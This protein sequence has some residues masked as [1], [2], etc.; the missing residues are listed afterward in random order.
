MKP[1]DVGGRIPRLRQAFADAGCGALLVTRLVNIRYLT[2]FTGSAA[3]LLVRPDDLVFVTDGRYRDQ[4]ALE[5]G[6]AG[7][8]ARIRIG[9]TAGSQKEYLQE[10]VA[11][12]ARLGLEASSVSWAAQR[13]YDDDW[14]PDAELVATE[15][16]VEELRKVKDAGEVER[17][18]AAARIADEALARVRHR[19]AEGPTEEEFALE[20]D[21]EMRRGGA[22]GPSF[23]TIVAS[24][25]NGAKPH[26][27]PS[28]RRIERGELVVVDFGAL[29]DGYCSDM[30]R[31][32][33]VG[34]PASATARRMV[35]VVAESQRA[36]VEAVRAGAEGKAVDE[37]CREIIAEAGWADAFLHSTGHGV[38]L[39]IHEA[40]TVSTSSTD[41][42]VAGHVVTVEPGVY[43]PEHGGVRIEDTM[44]VTAEG[45]TVL[46]NA[47]KELAVL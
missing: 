30:T 12:V 17:M 45:C 44:V 14:F 3:L 26:H 42:L 22:T 11:G 29:V 23:E 33:C 19:L 15:G 46:T 39:D 41:T 4:S 43:L 31:T 8:D 9:R 7:V 40:P 35:D 6:E 10:E 34:E 18:A 13:R 25:P 38:G 2:G 28:G 21:F 47:T 1:M 27:R 32:L 24:G 20:L 5:L 36:G 37:V 16:M